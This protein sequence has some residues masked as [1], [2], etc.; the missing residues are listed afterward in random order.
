M[1]KRRAVLNR[2]ADLA[3]ATELSGVADRGNQR[4]GGQRTNSLE[5][6]QTTESLVGAGEFRD[7]P[8]P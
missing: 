6:H 1:Q 8:V 3:S 7:P 4:R 2:L 5:R